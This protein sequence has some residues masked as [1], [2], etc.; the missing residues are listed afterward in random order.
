M[1]LLLT[2]FVLLLSF[3]S[4]DNKEV[5]KTLVILAKGLPS[6]SGTST[7]WER[8]A[9]LTIK[10]IKPIAE[11]MEGSEKPTLDGQNEGN[12]KEDIDFLDFHNQRVFLTSSDNIF[13]GRGTRIS[14][15]GR[16]VLSD[17]AALLRRV[18]NRMVISEN[19]QGDD[20]SSPPRRI[21]LQRAWAVAEY[22]TTKQGVDKMRFSISAASTV[23]RE[24]LPN[25]KPYLLR[26]KA[27]RML[28]ITIL[29][30]SIYN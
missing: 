9:F 23:P 14:S 26:S 3:S 28:E 5:R 1:T 22:L 7:A 18:P 15:K 16:K 17:M 27:N 25:S 8:D 12:P 10:Q 21:G 24:D 4:F 20:K 13:W 19:G 30:R 2:F 29:E 11:P 6:A